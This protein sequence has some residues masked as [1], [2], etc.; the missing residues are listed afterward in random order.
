MSQENKNLSRR[1]FEGFSLG[2]LD[3]IDELLA[4]DF[5]D[6][7]LYPGAEPNREGWKQ[8]A[9]KEWVAFP[10]FRPQI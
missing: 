3:A 7:T 8:Y 9:T 4:P 6:L 5:V 1:F 2:D 10:D